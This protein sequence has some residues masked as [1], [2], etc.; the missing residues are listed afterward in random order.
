MIATPPPLSPGDS[1]LDSLLALVAKAHRSS[2][3]T[4]SL[5]LLYEELGETRVRRHAQVNGL[6][7]LVGVVIDEEGLDLSADW[8]AA[9][10]VNRRR[11]EEL[12]RTATRVGRD[13]EKEGC[14]TALI[15][16]AA[17]LVSTGLPLATYSSQDMD[18]LVAAGQWTTVVRVLERHGFAPTDR[19][20]H[21]TI[22]TE[23][24]KTTASGDLW[25]DVG[26]KPFDRVWTPLTYHDRSSAWLA[27]RVSGS[28]ADE[29]N[30]LRPSHT[31]ALAV[32]HASLHSFVRAPGLRLYIDIDRTVS[33]RPI[34]WQ[35]FVD[36][37]RKMHIDTRA[38]IALTTSQ[39]LLGT[40]VDPS[41]LDTLRPSRVRLH[42]LHRLLRDETPLWSSKRKLPRHK[43]IAL[44]ACISQ[45]S[46]ARWLQSTLV[47]PE[48]WMR[49]HFDRTQ[50]HPPLWMLHVKRLGQGL[51]RWRPC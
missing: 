21:P 32:M 40:R 20:R 18:F 5:A 9:L 11:V 19:H 2:A 25:L 51:T 27:E 47:P 45:E 1:S 28:T 50:K 3:E 46:P 29:V 38:Y 43:A 26:P 42:A 12:V 35:S 48:P 8:R 49:E 22:R 23:F 16:G 39:T 33:H 24:Q 31:L 15:E 14:P 10:D 7:H 37:V 30:V 6:E 17:T 44:D 36:E 41:V 34:D 13:L 4:S